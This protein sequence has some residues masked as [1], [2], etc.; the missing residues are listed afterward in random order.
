MFGRQPMSTAP[1]CTIDVRAVINAIQRLKARDFSQSFFAA[2][3]FSGPFI[4]IRDTTL[5]VP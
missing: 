1:F 3:D 4:H 5:G 2:R